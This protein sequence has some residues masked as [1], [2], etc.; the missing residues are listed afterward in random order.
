MRVTAA[1][2][3]DTVR[4]VHRHMPL[5]TS[6]NDKVENPFHEHACEFAAAVEC[7]AE[8]DKFW[9][10]NDA[11]FSVQEHVRVADV[12][13]A[14]LAGQVEL[15][16]VAFQ[17]C[18]KAG[19]VLRRVRADLEAAYAKQIVGTPTYFIRNQQFPGGI[20]EGIL[21]RRVEAARERRARQPDRSKDA[22]AGR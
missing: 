2:F 8:Q 11:V 12:D 18:V 3:A 6:C 17:K 19:R 1:K 22:P 4:L 14:R 16:V 7:A 21:E 10:M 13:L 20:S 5:D 9:Q 15:D